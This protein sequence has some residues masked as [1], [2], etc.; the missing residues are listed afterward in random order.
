MAI[1]GLLGKGKTYGLGFSV[2]SLGS[3]R[4][5]SVFLGLGLGFNLE[6]GGAEFQWA[7]SLSVDLGFGRV[8]QG[9]SDSGTMWG[10]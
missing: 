2:Q 9:S 10:P 7:R 1:A 6:P 8:Q 5:G 4:V 3:T